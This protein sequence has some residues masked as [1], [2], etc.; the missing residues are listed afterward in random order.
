MACKQTLNKAKK[1]QQKC[2]I[3]IA[4]NKVKP[5]DAITLENNYAQP[6]IDATKK[7]HVCTVGAFFIFDVNWQDQKVTS[8]E[9]INFGTSLMGEGREGRM[10]TKDMKV[11]IT[12][13]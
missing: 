1:Y 11:S 13:G 4:S 10:F 9:W 7:M 6:Q 12:L 3:G 5:S 8:F 2:L